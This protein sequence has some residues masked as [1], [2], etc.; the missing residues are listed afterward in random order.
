LK[1]KIPSKFSSIGAKLFLCFWLIVVLTTGI[2]RLVSEQFRTKSFIAPSHRGDIVK[3]ER[4]DK[5]IKRDAPSTPKAVLSVLSRRAERELLLKNMLTNEVYSSDK[6]QI[7]SLQRFLVENNLESMATV[8]FEFYRMT[9]PLSVD[10]KG[11]PYQLFLAS[12]DRKP[13]FGSFIRGMPNWIRLAIPIIIST[14]LLWLLTRSLTKPLIAMQKAAVRFGDGEFSSRMPLIAQRNDEIGACAVSF[15]LMAE[16]LEQNIGSH[17]RLMAD[18]SHELRSPMTRLQIALGLAQQDNISPEILH[19]HLQRC[20]LEVTRLDEMIASVLSLSRMENTINQMELMAVD[21]NQ[22]LTL[23][24][25]DAQYIANEK[26]ITITLHSEGTAL[27]QADANL[28]SSAINNIL[29]NAVKY[30]HES[31]ELSVNLTKTNTHFVIDIIDQ[32]IG[33]PA[34]DIPRLF[35]PFYRVAQARDRATGGTGLGMAIAKQAIA[36]HNGHI[37]AKNNINNGLTVTIELPLTISKN[38]THA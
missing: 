1:L 22:L 24:I 38:N 33:V 17:Q 9:G 23:C 35:E 19:K 7:E 6:W 31:D 34:A 14:I 32:G 2:T 37:S 8:K 26:S 16:K 21:L 29:I 28:L 4:I 10:I 3:I 13:H 18:V 25:E 27:L 12:R 20:E 30:S 36:A 11:T 15:N 5:L